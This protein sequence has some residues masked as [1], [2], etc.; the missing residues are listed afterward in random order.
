MWVGCRESP[1]GWVRGTGYTLGMDSV[2]F[3]RALGIGAR[4]AAKTV[5]EAV[6]AATA[7]NPSAKPAAEG[8]VTTGP[9]AEVR[10]STGAQSGARVPLVEKAAQATAQVRQTQEGLKRGGKQFREAVGSPL[11]RLSGV[12]WLE[13][14]GV[15]FGL[16]AVSAAVGAWKLRTGFYGTGAGHGEHTQF[17]IAAAVAVVFGY[18]CVSS[19][20]RARRRERKR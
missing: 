9:V 16:F 14:T 13:F 2:R 18:F 8:G 10:S 12:L 5:A 11:V 7:P 6:D 17:L 3:G 20:V 19:F 1:L 4:L 15:F